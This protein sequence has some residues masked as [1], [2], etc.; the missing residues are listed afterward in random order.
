MTAPQCHAGTSELG[1]CLKCLAETVAAGEPRTGS[2]RWMHPFAT[3][4]EKHHAWLAPVACQKLHEVHNASAPFRLTD[5]L[6]EQPDVGA[7]IEM[8][9]MAG[10]A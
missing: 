10:A 9:L 8:G 3:A 4:C 1:K 2:R 6:L 5:Q 7:G